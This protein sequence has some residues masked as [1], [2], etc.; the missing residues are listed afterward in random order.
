[1]ITLTSFL[2]TPK[3]PLNQLITDTGTLDDNFDAALAALESTDGS[4]ITLSATTVNQLDLSI[5]SLEVSESSSLLFPENVRYRGSLSSGSWSIGFDRG[6]FFNRGVL[7]SSRT[8]K[9]IALRVSNGAR[10][11]LHAPVS[12]HKVLNDVLADSHFNRTQEILD[13]KLDFN[14][15]TLNTPKSHELED[16]HTEILGLQDDEIGED[17]LQSLLYNGANASAATAYMQALQSVPTLNFTEVNLTD[18]AMILGP[19]I[20]IRASSVNL[21]N[22]AISADGL[23]FLGGDNGDNPTVYDTQNGIENDGISGKLV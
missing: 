13:L 21:H 4:H 3:S 18:N 9:G 5:D 22:S 7:Q 1:M 12:Y 17:I 8:F 20:L 19:V 16:F 23:G 2:S 14:Y 11:V 6:I 15:S 10:L